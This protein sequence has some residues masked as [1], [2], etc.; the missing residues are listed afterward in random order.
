MT[1]ERP[2]VAKVGGSLFDLP[3]L[4]PRLRAWL[5]QLESRRVVLIPGGGPTA[6]AI[7][8]LDRTHHLGD[9]AAHWLA[10]RAMV[11]N[12]HFLARLLPAS[13]V[14]ARLAE[15]PASWQSKLTP[16]LDAHAFALAD[17]GQPGSLPHRWDVTSDSVAARVA[18]VAGARR[19]ILLKSIAIPPHTAWADA[20][21][22]GWVDGYFGEV[23]QGTGLA[24]EVMNFGQS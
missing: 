3:D 19:L 17:E 6:D 7:R 23:V 11:L 22:Q 16:I 24:V 20:G 5:G 21:R 8:T 12:A 15:C 9:E 1:D 10:L 4:G 14:V 13:Q 18:I 2:V